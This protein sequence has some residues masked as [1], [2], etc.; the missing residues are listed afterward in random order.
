[1]KKYKIQSQEEGCGKV[2]TESFDNL[3]DASAYIQDRWQGPDYIDGSDGFH[4]DYSTYEVKGFTLR[5]I[6]KLKVT[7]EDGYPYREFT[8][9]PLEKLQ[10]NEA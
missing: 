4:T 10:E 2:Y 5:D 6:G 3:A 7:I 1:M 9:H 8:F